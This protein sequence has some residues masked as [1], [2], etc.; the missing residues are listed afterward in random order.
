MIPPFFD[1]QIIGSNTVQ[2]EVSA[3]VFPSSSSPCSGIFL[4]PICSSHIN[5]SDTDES[6]PT[7]PLLDRSVEASSPSLSPLHRCL[8]CSF[9]SGLHPKPPRCR[10]E[11]DPVAKDDLPFPTDPLAQCRSL[12][13]LFRQTGLGESS[14]RAKFGLLPRRKWFSF[15]VFLLY[16]M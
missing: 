4:L 6:F 2:S 8:S 5:M 9:K 16:G 7:A 10:K 1:F 14:Q 3:G 11:F 15:L 13:N 12:V